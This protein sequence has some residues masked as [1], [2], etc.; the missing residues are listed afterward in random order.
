MA[1]NQAIEKKWYLNFDPGFSS[2][3]MKLKDLL[4]SSRMHDAILPIFREDYIIPSMTYR[5]KIGFQQFQRK[6]SS[7][8][9]N[10]SF[11]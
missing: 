9:M 1:K 6:N 8:G 4:R 5:V 7:D 3:E 2:V 11:S 10:D